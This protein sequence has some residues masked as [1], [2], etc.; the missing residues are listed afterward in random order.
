MKRA[1][2]KTRRRFATK[3]GSHVDPTSWALL[4]TAKD[5]DLPSLVYPIVGFR[6][7]LAG[8]LPR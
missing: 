8:R 7:S 6:V 4:V 3:G 1:P 2:K 5:G